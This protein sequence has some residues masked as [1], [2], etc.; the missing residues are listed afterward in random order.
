MNVNIPLKE[1]FISNTIVK[2]AEYIENER[3]LK[4]EDTAV[5]PLREEFLV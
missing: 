1:V 5:I 2:M 4:K 3:W